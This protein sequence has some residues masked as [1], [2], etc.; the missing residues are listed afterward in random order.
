MFPFVAVAQLSSE[1]FERE[2]DQLRFV[3]YNVENIFHPSD[4]ADKRDEEFTPKGDRNWSNYRYFEKLNRSAKAILATGGFTPPEIVGLCEI[5]NKQVLFDFTQQSV[6][7]NYPFGIVHFESPDKRGID[8]AL[9]YNKDKFK[10]IHKKAIPIVFPWDANYKT[11][12][13]LWVSVTHKTDTFHVFVNHWPSRWRGYLETEPS[14]VHVAQTLKLVTD[15]LFQAN[16]NVKLVVM[17]DFNDTPSDKSIS[18]VLTGNGENYFQNLMNNLDV[19]PGSNKHGADWSYIDQI[20]ISKAFG[21]QKG[22]KYIEGSVMPC[23]FEFLLEKDEKN[24]G[25]KPKRTF[26]GLKYREGFSDHLPIKAD[27]TWKD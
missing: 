18:E 1:L 23:A 17:G 12:D 24:L 21:S 9:L 3:F 2:T 13:I 11:R 8:V 10:V 4:D 7:N 19:F 14:R 20:L 15:S 22:L 5:E 6:L 27:F 16:N 25:V 26:I